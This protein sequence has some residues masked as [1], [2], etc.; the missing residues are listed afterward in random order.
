MTVFDTGYC[1]DIVDG[2]GWSGSLQWPVDSQQIREGRGFRPGHSAI[3]IEMALES[4]VYA[5]DSGLVL[6]AGFSRWGG[7]NTV[8]LAHG[9]TYQTF[10]HHL[11]TVNVGCDQYISRGTVIGTVGQTGASNFPHLHFAVHY[12]GFNFDPLAWL[13]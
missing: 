12:N 9:N 5:A 4:P 10:Y 11:S 3:D 2:S 1:G 7:G 8:V 13:P 6:W